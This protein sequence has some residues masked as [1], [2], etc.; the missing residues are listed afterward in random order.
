MRVRDDQ[1]HAAQAALDQ[2]AQEA[3]PE[4]FG[5]ALADIE[6]DHLPVARLV[7]G[8][9]EHERLLHDPAAVADLLNLGVQPQVRVA[10]LERPIAERVHL[11]VQAGA[12]SGDLALRDPQPE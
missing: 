6:A 3:A 10:A 12:D 2:A 1:L 8:I 5:L 11:L 4:R 9:G 7:D